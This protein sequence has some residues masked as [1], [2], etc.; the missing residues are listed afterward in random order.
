MNQCHLVIHTLFTY[1]CYQSPLCHTH[2]H[3]W[4]N[5]TPFRYITLTGLAGMEEVAV[6]S[7]KHPSDCTPITSKVTG[8]SGK[9]APS[10]EMIPEGIKS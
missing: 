2:A 3:V 10:Q 8:C 1:T 9:T 7:V 6:N 4:V 5:S